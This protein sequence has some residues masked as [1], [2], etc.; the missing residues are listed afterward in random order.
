MRPANVVFKISV[1]YEKDGKYFHKNPFSG[2]EEE[3]RPKDRLDLIQKDRDQ[4]LMDLGVEPKEQ[5]G[6]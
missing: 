2:K 6:L 4:I 5:S 3:V 1:P